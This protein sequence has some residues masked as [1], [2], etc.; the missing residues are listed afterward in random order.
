M[1][2]ISVISD[3]VRR[4]TWTVGQLRTRAQRVK[5]RSAGDP[6]AADAIIDEALELC[7]NLLVD[8][9][10]AEEETRKLRQA[11]QQERQDAIGLF[12]RIPIPSVSTDEAG[13]ITGANR[14]A[15]LLLNVSARHLAGKP[16][17]HFTQD[18]VAF[19][20]M[21]G[22]L[23][24]D[25]ST[26]HGTISIRP[27]ERRTLAVEITVVSQTTMNATEWLWFLTP[28]ASGERGVER[29]PLQLP[30]DVDSPESACAAESCDTAS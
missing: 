17:L 14:H 1:S 18:R 24:Q 13:L 28:E 21:L 9:A 16:L 12:D 6:A 7:N 10:G 4:W 20:A 23:P 26:S 11:L 30:R 2:H 29:D 15:A 25:G 27:R 5:R 3:S 19:L 22:S 8:L